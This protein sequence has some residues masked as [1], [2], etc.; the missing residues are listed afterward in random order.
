[1]V[2]RLGLVS[3]A[4]FWPEALTTTGTPR[5]WGESNL[6]ELTST[7]HLLL[8]CFLPCVNSIT[9][10]PS[11][12]TTRHLPSI[13]SLKLSLILSTEDYT[14]ETPALHADDCDNVKSDKSPPPDVITSA[15]NWVCATVLILNLLA[16]TAADGV[17]IFL[18]TWT[19]TYFDLIFLT[20]FST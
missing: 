19:V 15:T 13:P 7:A 9:I 16:V 1:M 17:N 18:G 4:W 2:K 12:W 10:L 11:K 5:S 8:D 6:G 3:L 14:A 20:L